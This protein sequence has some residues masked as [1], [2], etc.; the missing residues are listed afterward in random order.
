[1]TQKGGLPGGAAQP[2]GREEMGEAKLW[3]VIIIELQVFD[4]GQRI[5]NT[6]FTSNGPIHFN[7]VMKLSAKYSYKYV[8]ENCLL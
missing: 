3:R 7:V 8:Y 4:Q 5:S 6:G 2:A 1:M